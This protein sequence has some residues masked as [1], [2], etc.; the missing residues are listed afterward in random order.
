V[1]RQSDA[2]TLSGRGLKRRQAEQR[3]ERRQ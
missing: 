2:A 3:V 1:A